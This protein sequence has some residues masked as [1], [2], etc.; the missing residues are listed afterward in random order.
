MAVQADLSNN[1]VVSCFLVG[2]HLIA[3]NF[4]LGCRLLK[5]PVA[6]PE[7]GNRGGIAAWITTSLRERARR[8]GGQDAGAGLAERSHGRAARGPQT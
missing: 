2:G 1:Y 4:R 3:N 5:A 6:G 7:A 8:L